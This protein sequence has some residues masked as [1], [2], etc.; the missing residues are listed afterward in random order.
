MEWEKPCITVIDMNAEI[1]SYQPD[2]GDEPIR[3][4]SA[5]RQASDSDPAPGSPAK[6]AGE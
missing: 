1:G 5:A 3:G 6:P 2:F 4:I